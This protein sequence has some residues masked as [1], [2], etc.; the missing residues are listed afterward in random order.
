[1]LKRTRWKFLTELLYGIAVVLLLL[2]KI[3]VDLV[4][5]TEIVRN[6]LVHIG[7]YE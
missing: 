4:S 1:V 2:R 5:M 3:R 7:Q 6:H